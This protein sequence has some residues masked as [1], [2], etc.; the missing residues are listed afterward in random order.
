MK[1]QITL[2]L[3]SLILL[4]SVQ[5]Q[6]TIHSE[7]ESQLININGYKINVE[8]KGKGNPIVFIAGG[9]GNS[10][11]YMQGNFGKYYKNRQVVFFDGLGRGLSD[12]AKD[13]KEYSI[14]GDVET[15]EGIRKALQLSKWT[16]V[17]HSYGT[18]VAQAYALKYPQYTEKMILIN[19][20]HSGLMWQANCDSYNHYAKTHFPEKWTVVD[21]LRSEGFV[22]SDPEFSKVYGDFPTKY[23]YYHN[24]ELKQPVPKDVKRSWNS[25]VY[26]TIV[27]RDADFHV[28]GDMGDIDFRRE[29]KKIQSP[30]LIIAGRYD[31][32]STPEFAIQYKTYMPKAK[33]VMF[34]KSGHNPYLEEP[35]K[36]FELFESF[37]EIKH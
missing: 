1:T 23:I 19:G 16:V 24:T 32:V 6:E 13:I 18:V 26:Y 36:F 29:L 35:E 4:F 27:G 20:F 12:D 33:F 10:H 15:L 11:D 3:V 21:S 22:S 28:T 34:E 31:G 5:A 37:L 25:A 9:P 8:T 2:F 14:Q 17:G 7:F 30:T